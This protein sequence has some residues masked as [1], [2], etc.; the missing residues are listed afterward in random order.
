MYVRACG[1]G[2]RLG[3]GEADGPGASEEER[4]R[5]LEMR[6]AARGPQWGDAMIGPV[7]QITLQHEMRRRALLDK[8]KAAWGG[9]S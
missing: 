7:D 6:R 1:H 8:Q 4:R 2:C 9:S 5:W 3:P